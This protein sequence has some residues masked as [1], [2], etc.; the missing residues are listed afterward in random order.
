MGLTRKKRN[1]FV[2]VKMLQRRLSQSL[3]HVK[4]FPYGESSEQSKIYLSL[5]SPAATA[6]NGIQEEGNCEGHFS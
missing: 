3:S 2:M 4:E 6:R 1:Q 5:N